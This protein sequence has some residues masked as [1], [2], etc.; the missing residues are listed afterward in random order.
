MRQRRTSV[1][2]QGLPSIMPLVTYLMDDRSAARAGPQ[3]SAG[4]GPLPGTGARLAGPRRLRIIAAAAVAGI[5]VGPAM[6]WVI[7]QRHCAALPLAI[8]GG[9]TAVI[10][11]ILS[12]IAVMYEARQETMRAEIEH[13]SASTIAAALARYID[14]AAGRPDRG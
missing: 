5:P 4:D 1:P 13:R 14:R 12:T 7:G 9:V 10:A 2:E 8:G 6:A 3:P 11:A